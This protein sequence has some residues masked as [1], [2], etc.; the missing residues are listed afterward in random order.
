MIGRLELGR[1]NVPERFEEAAAVVPRDPLERREL[2]IFEP[3]PRPATMDLLG[4]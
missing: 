2:D 3:L 1:G 4:L